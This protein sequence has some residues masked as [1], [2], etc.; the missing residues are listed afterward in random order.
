M[1]R[2]KIELMIQEVKAFP[3]A[4]IV[5]LNIEYETSPSRVDEILRTRNLPF[6]DADIIGFYKEIRSFKFEWTISGKYKKDENFRNKVPWLI[7]PEETDETPFASFNFVPIEA[8]FSIV[9]Y[10]KSSTDENERIQFNN[11]SF[12]E[13]AC[14]PDLK[15]F[16]LFSTFTCAAFLLQ[17]N[18]TLVFCL[19]DYYSTVNTTNITSFS[20]YFDFVIYCKGIFDLRRDALLSPHNGGLLTLNQLIASITIPE[21]F[22][23]IKK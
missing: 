16:D 5:T 9:P 7:E 20:A 2:E 4:E 10:F 21:V 17:K 3:F 22:L 11:G 18:K 14:Y 6:L 23:S 8:V 15:L 12:N 19:D 1:F 13:A